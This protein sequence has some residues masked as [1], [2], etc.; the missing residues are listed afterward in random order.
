VIELEGTAGGI[1]EKTNASSGF[2]IPPRSVYRAMGALA[3]LLCAGL[4][5]WPAPAFSGTPRGVF[6]VANV[7]KQPSATV[8][9]NPDVDGISLRQMW[10]TLEPQENV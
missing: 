10:S 8:L 5:G 4:L 3:A 6:S 1:M 7:D 9:A 2:I